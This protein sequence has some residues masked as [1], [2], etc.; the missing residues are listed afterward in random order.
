MLISMLILDVKFNSFKFNDFRFDSL[1]LKIP[2][3]LCY[4]MRNF[5]MHLNLE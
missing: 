5:V 1:E 4:S 3:L 2:A